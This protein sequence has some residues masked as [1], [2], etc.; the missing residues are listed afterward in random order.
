MSQNSEKKNKPVS[1]KLA[2]AVIIALAVISIV[3][4]Y[5]RNYMPTSEHMNLSD[6]YGVSGDEMVTFFN[7]EE[8][9][10]D[11]P[12]S[13]YDNGTY[14]LKLSFVKDD[15]D[16]GYVYDDTEDIL[17]YT[18][19]SD[20]YSV[21]L[22]ESTY[23]N[24]RNSTDMNAP[25]VIE[26]NG[27]QYLSIDYVHLFS[28]FKSRDYDSPRR[29]ILEKAGY[30]RKTATLLKD[31]A[32]RK[33][34]G[35]KSLILKDAGKDDKV[36]VEENYGS[37]SKVLTSDGVIGCVKNSTLSAT[38]ETKTK[39]SLPKRTYSHIKMDKS[40][41]LLWHQVTNRTANSSISSV[42]NKAEGINV[43]SPTWFKV[44][45]NEG[46]LSDIASQSYVDECHNM[47]VEVWA[48]FSNFENDIDS[49]SLLN[50]TSSRDNLINNI[51]GKAIAYN[52]DGINIDFEALSSDAA[53]GYA[54]FIRELSIKCENND[55]VLSVDNYPPTESSKFYNRSLQADYADYSIV[56]AYDEHYSGS[57]EA[58]SNSSLPFV[59]QAVADTLEE[60]PA[61]Q[62]I[63][64]LP[65]YSRIWVSDGNSLSNRSI[66]MNSID[67]WLSEHNAEETWNDELGQNYAEY[68]EDN[69]TYM[70]WIEDEKSLAEKLNV[71]KSNGLA[72]GAFWKEGFEDADVWNLI[73]KYMNN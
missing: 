14:Y 71:M 32:I 56:M 52:L 33:N 20:V 29:L 69:K 51:I 10:G 6:F 15:L 18:T 13:I 48:L 53:D 40:V 7:G 19:D 70:L 44:S 38:K 28:D 3:I 49:T 62:L 59:K 12:A 4:V 24:G 47:G 36:T 60:V 64:G 61:N 17:R 16:D 42:L 63:L 73:S 50:T 55:I 43:I 5:I 11:I 8:V 67:D 26:D 21:N 45:D 37:W 58:G 46:G 1:M 30:K 2:F 72:G 9:E 34:G 22:N 27:T 23:Q 31:T 65:F 39:K 54:E 68:T 66:G 57:E 25:I 41:N 35:P